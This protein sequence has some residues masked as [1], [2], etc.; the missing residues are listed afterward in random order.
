MPVSLHGQVDY[1]ALPLCLIWSL[2]LCQVVEDWESL[3]KVK[4]HQWLLAPAIYARTLGNRLASAS[5]EEETELLA[6]EEVVF[7]ALTMFDVSPKICAGSRD[8]SVPIYSALILSLIH[9]CRCRR[10]I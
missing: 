7:S 2:D 1:S 8:G 4:W 6:R 3:K 9:I 5:V 10:A